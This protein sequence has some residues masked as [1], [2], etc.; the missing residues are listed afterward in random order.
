M[1]LTG[2]EESACEQHSTCTCE[3]RASPS[4]GGT[5]GCHHSLNVYWRSLGADGRCMETCRNGVCTEL[6]DESVSLQQQLEK[7]RIN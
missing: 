7:Q 2:T 6:T 4:K 3:G 5:S 1:V